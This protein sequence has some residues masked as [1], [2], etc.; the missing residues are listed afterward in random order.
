MSWCLWCFFSK[1]EVQ[2]Q[3]LERS[4]LR[5]VCSAWVTRDN[6]AADAAASLI[7]LPS[8]TTSPSGLLLGLP[9]GLLLLLVPRLGLPLELLK[10]LRK[11]LLM[12]LRTL[13][14]LQELLLSNFC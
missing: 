11:L 12:L 10:L 7:G 1:E 5:R 2:G 4:L 6:I 14:L 9:L 13:L 8:N 3:Q